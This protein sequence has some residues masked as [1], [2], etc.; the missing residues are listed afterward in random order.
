MPPATTIPALPV[1]IFIAGAINAVFA[2]WALGALVY[3]A[4]RALGSLGSYRR[5]RH[6][7]GFAS[8]PIALSLL[9]FW[10][11]RIGVYG[12]DLFRSGGN[13]YGRGDTIFGWVGY[14]FVAWSVVLLA[15][16]IRAVH[17]WSRPRAAGALGLTALLPAL[18]TLQQLL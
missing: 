18:L 17:G 16:G 10:P 12:I 14:G 2:Y 9:V 8:V 6:V 4:C 3:V 7:V 5:A 11:V 13:D 15:I 1:W